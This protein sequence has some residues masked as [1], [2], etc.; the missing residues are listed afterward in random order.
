MKTLKKLIAYTF[1]GVGIGT[2]ATYLAS[3]IIGKGFSPAIPVFLEQFPD[4]TTAIG[5]QL[6]IFAGLGI[7]QGMAGSIFSKVDAK[8]SLLALTGIHYGLIV[9]PLLLAGWYLRWFSLNLPAFIGFLLLVSGIYG[10]VY[11]FNYL[12][13][14]K[15][16][17]EINTK[18][19]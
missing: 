2:L 19:G 15:D 4:K 1:I 8:R 18:L 17:R 6:M 11:L 5:V 10:V 3:L 7:L 13:I 12:A 14:K 16:I 9:L